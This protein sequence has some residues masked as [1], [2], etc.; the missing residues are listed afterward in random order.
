MK[1][2]TVVIRRW[3]ERHKKKSFNKSSNYRD[4]RSKIFSLSR[5]FDKYLLKYGTII[6]LLD[7][8]LMILPEY[9]YSVMLW[10]FS[11]HSL[12][13]TTDLTITHNNTL[14]DIL[15]SLMKYHLAECI[16]IYLPRKIYLFIKKNHIVYMSTISFNTILD[17]SPF[18]IFLIIIHSLR[19]LYYSSL[20]LLCHVS[21]NRSTI[22]FRFCFTLHTSQYQRVLTKL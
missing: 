11:F 9:L 2:K 4:I 7:W 5:H 18:Q 20:F 6:T 1:H 13:T 12:L 16:N 17:T 8:N 19:L 15:N 10:F 14:L 3:E 22:F 21:L